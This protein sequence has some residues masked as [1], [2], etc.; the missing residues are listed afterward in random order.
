MT[1]AVI[2]EERQRQ[3][4]AQDQ[5]VR[6]AEHLADLYASGDPLP[7]GAEQ[8]KILTDAHWSDEQLEQAIAQAVAV[9]DQALAQQR[10]H[11][12]DAIERQREYNGE[13]GGKLSPLEA[14]KSTLAT[15]LR[16]VNDEIEEILRQ[17]KPKQQ[18][19]SGD[20]QHWSQVVANGE[21]QVSRR[22]QRD[23]ESRRQASVAFQQAL[24]EAESARD[25]DYAWGRNCTELRNKLAALEGA[26]D[27]AA[28]EYATATRA[29]HAGYGHAGDGGLCGA[30]APVPVLVDRSAEYAAR[31]E[32][33]KAQLS[34]AEQGEKAANQRRQQADAEVAKIDAQ[35][36]QQ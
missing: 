12:A 17:A 26:R 8:L 28:A 4:C 36:S 33:L 9:K 23:H 2:I 11:L 20:V 25:N 13:L 6:R 1:I 29:I 34:Q 24:R 19:L 21:A 7:S 10:G 18:E 5:L 35:L 31:I 32:A 15:Q 27:R 22:Q 14:L 16:G 3:Q 30:S